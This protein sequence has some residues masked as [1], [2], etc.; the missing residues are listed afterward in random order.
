MLDYHKL[1]D[2]LHHSNDLLK[3]ATIELIKAKPKLYAATTTLQ[4]VQEKDIASFYLPIIELQQIRLLKTFINAEGNKYLLHHDF[5][6]TAI[7]LTRAGVD[8]YLHVLVSLYKE[9]AVREVNET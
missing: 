1:P 6:Q 3:Q 8:Y 9:L 4:F 7:N 5:A 2:Y